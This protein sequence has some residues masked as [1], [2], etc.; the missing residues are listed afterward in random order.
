[1]S[2]EDP[3][4]PTFVGTQGAVSSSHWLASSSALAVL[5]DHGNAFDAAV[6]AAFVLHVVEPHENGPG[7]DVPIITRQKVTG[8]VKVLCGQGPAPKGATIDHFQ[9]LGLDLI[10]GSGLLPACVPGAVGAWLRLLSDLG[11]K[12]LPDVLRFAIGYASQGYPVS[13]ELRDVLIEHEE[14]FRRH[15]TSSGEVYLRNGV[16]RVGDLI[17]NPAM[18][19]TL[20]T[21]CQEATGPSREAR[22]RS[23]MSAWY[24]GF[25]ASA[26]DDFMDSSVVA[27]TAGNHHRGILK[28]DDLASWS[29]NWEPAV[30][31]RYRGFEVFK[32]GPWGQGPVFLQQLSLLQ[33]FDLS[34][35][36]QNSTDYAHIV[37]ES[38]KLSFADREAWYGD[39][40]FLD[41]PL[42]TL[43]SASY[44]TERRSMIGP[45]ASGRL[46]PGWVDGDAPRLPKLLPSLAGDV[47][48]APNSGSVGDTCAIAVAD[49]S[50]NSVIALPSGGWIRSSPLI[51]ALGFPLGTRAQMFWLEDG[52]P[53]SLAPGKRPRTTLSPSLAVKDDGG[54]LAFGSPGGDQQDQ[55]SLLFFLGVA[56][57]NLHLTSAIDQPVFHSL[58]FPNSF[59]PRRHYPKRLVM[60]GRIEQEV[61][62]GMEERGHDVIRARL[63]DLAR[64]CAVGV[65][66]NPGILSAGASMRGIQANALA[67]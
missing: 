42:E 59:Y 21:L 33:G 61:V 14:M 47:E 7:G 63:W 31:Y 4:R 1:M 32:T 40:N 56:D 22:I 3:N 51:P 18:A 53:N 55:W 35:L 12:E 28:G 64:T 36:P 2:H 16:P 46:L 38:A 20:I 29:P 50:G 60:E 65:D 66:L 43:L 41:V 57:F 52:L 39:P 45:M 6:A 5:A 23:A 54:V 17:R 49:G 27:D 25:V 24:E 15:W 67:F 10:P 37:A 48:H 13:P 58:H 9:S 44:A 11:T 26:I 62:N 34:S 30:S 19:D 8:E